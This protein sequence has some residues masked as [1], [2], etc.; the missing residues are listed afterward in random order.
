M[1]FSGALPLFNKTLVVFTILCLCFAGP[2][3]FLNVCNFVP[4]FFDFHRFQFFEGV[5]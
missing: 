5:W 1:T 2:F 3:W 4:I